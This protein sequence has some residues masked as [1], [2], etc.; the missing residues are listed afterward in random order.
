L[1]FF[2]AGI[3]ARRSHREHS[4][5]SAGVP[6][7][8]PRG[9]LWSSTGSAAGRCPGRT[10]T[11][12]PGGNLASRGPGGR[13]LRSPLD[14]GSPGR[15]RRNSLGSAGDFRGLFFFSSILKTGKDR[16]PRLQIPRPGPVIPPARDFPVTFQLLSRYSPATFQLLPRHLPATFQ[17]PSSYSPATFQLLSSYFP[18]TFQP[19]SSHVPAAFQLPSSYFP[20]TFQLVS[21]HFPCTFQALSS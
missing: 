15:G 14:R 11:E 7:D 5:V 16:D 8:L 19:L 2:R 21:S 10:P 4:Q 1:R 3:G 18:F 12:S 20:I 13:R 6:E 17:L 9:R